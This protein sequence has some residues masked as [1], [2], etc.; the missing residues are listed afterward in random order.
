MLRHYGGGQPCS[1]PGH[2]DKA[3]LTAVAKAGVQQACNK[4]LSPRKERSCSKNMDME[5][6]VVCV[7]KAAGWTAP[8]HCGTP[9]PI[10]ATKTQAQKPIPTN[11][12]SQMWDNLSVK[13]MT[14]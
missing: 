4:I 3:A 12:T 10:S 9:H 11:P 8:G 14:T 13:E 2:W 6:D 1:W 5:P 7:V